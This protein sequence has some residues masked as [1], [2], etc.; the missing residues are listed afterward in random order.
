MRPVVLRKP[1]EDPR[2]S[3]VRKYPVDNSRFTERKSQ[4]D[5]VARRRPASPRIRMHATLPLSMLVP[6]ARSRACRPPMSLS[7]LGVCLAWALSTAAL[8]S[9]LLL[10]QEDRI[11]KGL[12]GVDRGVKQQS[13][14]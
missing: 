7:M 4:D 5:Q 13:F 3:S 9:S 12:A 10:L 11:A 8:P 6:L 2:H 1:V 14:A